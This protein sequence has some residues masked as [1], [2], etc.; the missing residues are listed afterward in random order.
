MKT[1]LEPPDRLH[2]EAAEGWIGL[3]DYSSAAQELESITAANRTQPDVL[4]LRWRISAEAHDWDACLDI[5]SSLTTSNPNRLFGWIHRAKSLYQLGRTQE[6]KDLLISVV[7]DF[8]SNSTVPFHLARYCCVLGQ[9]DEALRWLDRAV[10]AADNPE[11]LFRL[12][13]Q[14]VEDPALEPLRR[15]L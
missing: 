9:A 12:R 14:L 11:E 6:A 10:A 15:R 3:G 7:D 1:S 5:S 2:L 13:R 8:Q 4:Q